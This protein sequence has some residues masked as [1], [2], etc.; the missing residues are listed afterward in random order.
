M[1]YKINSGVFGSIFTLPTEIAD[2]HLKLASAAQLKVILYIFRNL[3]TLP[4]IS[5]IAKQLRLPESEVEDALLYWINSSVLESAQAPKAEATISQ[6]LQEGKPKKTVRPEKILPSR[7]EVGAAM[8]ENEAFRDLLSEAQLK[9]CR[10]LKISESA[11][12]LWLLEDQGMDISLI[13]MLFE[14]A[15]QER[16][17]NIGF[18]EKTAISWLDSGI[19]SIYAAEQHI[20]KVYSQKTA[21][22]AVEKCFGIEDRKPS[23]KELENSHK[24]I[25][26]WGF[27]ED[28]L[29]AAYNACVDTK[30][31]FIM[32]YTV[33]ILEDWHN[34]GFKTP[35]DIKPNSPKKG[36][37]KNGGSS[38][39]TYDIDLVQQML[40]KGYGE[41][42]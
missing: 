28:M 29:K 8:S 30:S 2:R 18:I 36:N 25:N 23:D 7:T 3:S 42:D 17:C 4:N 22:K 38:I 40:G 16:R 37:P 32:S 35:A 9:F 26:E 14:Y 24:W 5:E 19:D 6:P 34:A 20:K 27:G 41:E 15:V 11:T 1:E 33:K 10:T 31:K 12:L 39:A 13:L 21:W